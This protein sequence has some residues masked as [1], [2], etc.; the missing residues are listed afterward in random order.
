MKKII[1]TSDSHG[2]TYLLKQIASKHN[3]AIAYLHAGDS[4][5]FEANLY[6]FV[7]IKGNN[8]YY[9]SQESKTINIEPLRIYMTHGHKMYLKE[10]NMVAKAKQL[11]CNMFIYGHT[12][13]PF[14][15][16]VDGVHLL[17]PGACRYSRSIIGATYAIITISDNQEIDV[18]FETI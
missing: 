6:P 7:T 10:E 17:N 14:Y 15:Q 2:D 5:D 18:T 11:D 8:D 13:V 12:H 3:D 4:L 16:V 9:I 1:V